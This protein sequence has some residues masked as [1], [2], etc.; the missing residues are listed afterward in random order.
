MTKILGLDVSSSSTGYCIINNGRLLKS[1]L[2]TINPNSK[3]SYGERLQYFSEQLIYL[4]QE[5]NPD[6]V[7]VED[8]FRG[9]NAKTFKTLAMFR[10]VCFLT[11][12]NET[13]KNPISI[14]P[15]EARKL[16]GT[17]GVTKEDGFNFVM[18]KYA[19]SEYTFDTH[20]D[21]TDAIILGLACREMEKQGLSEKD[22]RS[23]KKKRK[24]KKRK[25]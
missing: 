7:V 6:K 17:Q 12:F 5:Y 23:K 25:K 11:V 15:T 9:P 21:I 16:V 20:N 1:T 3:S 13:G 8:I 22:L 19:F 2:G 10:G 24:R 14:M 18:N 4:I